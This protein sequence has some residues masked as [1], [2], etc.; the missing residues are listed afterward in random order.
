MQRVPQRDI[1]LAISSPPALCPSESV[2]HITMSKLNSVLDM[3]G[4]HFTAMVQNMAGIDRNQLGQEL[5]DLT[6]YRAEIVAAVDF[7]LSGI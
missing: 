7:V 1:A 6:H 2:A 3:D 5:G 4:D